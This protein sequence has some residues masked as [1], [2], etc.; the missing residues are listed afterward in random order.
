MV[1]AAC[2]SLV[3]SDIH[4][5]FS[6]LN[7]DGAAD[8]EDME[9]LW[10]R[11]RQA[12]N[13]IV[14]K[15]IGTRPARQTSWGRKFYIN[16][17]A[18]CKKASISRSWYIL[19]S[20]ANQDCDVLLNVWVKDRKNFILAWEKSNNVW[21]EEMVT[22]AV[23]KGDIAIWRL[24][25][26]QVK[27]RTR[28][29]VKE[30]GQILTDPDLIVEEL[31]SFHERSVL[32]NTSIPPGEFQ[33]AGWD[34]SF[35]MEKGPRWDLVLDV[36]NDLVLANVKKLKLSTVPD[37]I[38]PMLLKLLFGN[39]DTVKPLADLIR[40][41]VRTRIFP[42]SAKIARQIFVW[43]GKGERDSLDGCRTITMAGAVLKLSEACVKDA[44]ELFW[45]KAGFP[46][47]YWGQFSGAPESIYIW[48]STVECYI[49]RGYKPETT[50]T[51]VSKAFD[52]L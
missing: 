4:L 3:V 8:R 33:P 9:C 17:R 26:G 34:K 20:E 2:R 51:D 14:E 48:Q 15:R 24:L 52:R 44:G 46:C 23:Q 25:N 45:K 16:V 5:A 32:E 10:Q 7:W 37:N 49:R 27:K 40:A 19:A 39:K 42:A 41:V 50:L 35:V 18:L 36:S 31:K 47:P 6:P 12:F 21:L 29:L 43:K 22:Q 30:G 1:N 13:S 28:P 11:W 38:L